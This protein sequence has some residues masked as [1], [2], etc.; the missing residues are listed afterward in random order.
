MCYLQ[1]AI[2]ETSSSMKTQR[3]II[4]GL[5][6]MALGLPAQAQTPVAD[7]IRAAQT[8]AEEYRGG[9]QIYGQPAALPLL[10]SRPSTLL[11]GCDKE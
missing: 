2:K 7:R 4:V 1:E 8:F 10:H 3:I 5:L 11:F 9:S 6:A